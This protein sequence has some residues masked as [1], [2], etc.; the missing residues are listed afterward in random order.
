VDPGING[1]YTNVPGSGQSVAKFSAPK[2]TLM[3]YIIKASSE[4][5]SHGP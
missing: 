5:I 1:I 2:A 4:E 3:S